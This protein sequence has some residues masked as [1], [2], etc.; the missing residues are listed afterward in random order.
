MSP[1]SQKRQQHAKIRLENNMM[2]EGTPHDA[3]V[4]LRGSRGT[5]VPPT[6]TQLS[7]ALY[8]EEISQELAIMART[9]RLDSLAYF[10]DMTRLEAEIIRRS[11]EARAGS[12]PAQP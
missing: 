2:S 5:P 12:Q 4:L 10:I 7:V 11:C 6:H 1:P 8:I 9:A 3:G